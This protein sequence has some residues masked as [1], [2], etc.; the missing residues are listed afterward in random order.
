VRI[1]AIAHYPISTPLHGGQRRVA[2][3]RD[4]AR[5]AGHEFRLFPVYVSTS[6][7]ET[8]E[9]ERTTALPP[10]VMSTLQSSALRDDLHLARVFEP[11]HPGFRALVG[12]LGDFRPDIVQFEQPRLFPLLEDALTTTPG[13]DRARVVYSSQN[14]ETELI[15]DPWRAEAEAIERRLVQ[16]ADLVVAVSAADAARFQ[17]WR[18]PGQAPVIVAPNGCWAPDPAPDT[19]PARPMD[20]DFALVVGSAHPPNAQGYWDCI[21]MFPGFLPPETC[22]AVAGGMNALLTADDRFQRM[23]LLNREFLRSFGVV[24]EDQLQA[25]LYHARTILLPITEGGG[26]NLKTAEA[27][28]WLKPVVAMKPAMR[29]YED[30]AGLSG[31]FVAD[32]PQEFRALCREVMCGRLRSERRAGDVAQYGWPAQLEPLIGAYSTF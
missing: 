7:P 11:D 17:A 14:V 24:P 12:H 9:E 6:Y 25:L 21:G 28:M 3:I 32:D 29:G 23:P 16:R 1:A 20:E 27:L 31:V 15:N 2:A 10:D 19:P 22:L 8:T 4:R 26:T 30:A 5:A 13:L 18:A